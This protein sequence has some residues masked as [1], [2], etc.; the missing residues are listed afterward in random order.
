MK[1]YDVLV[2]GDLVSCDY[3]MAE[4]LSRFGMSTI[5]VRSRSGRNPISVPED[6]FRALPADH[7]IH[8][9]NALEF[10]S[11]ARKSRL[12][13]S[14]TGSLLFR[15]RWLWP[16][17]K[18]LGL[19]PVIHIM[20]GSDMTE[21][22]AERSL[23]GMLYRQYLRFVDL[24]WC[25]PLPHAL[26][27]CVD[28]KLRNVVF[29][30]GFPFLVP[31]I[32]KSDAY[33]GPKPGE[34]LRLFHC[35][36]FDWNLTDF[37]LQRN[38]I[39][40]NDKFLRAFIRAIKEGLDLRL[41]VLDRGADRLVAKEMLERGGVLDRVEWRGHLS[42][43]ELYEE[44]RRC[45]LVAN[46][47]AHGGAGGISFESMAL[48]RP[49]LQYANPT[50]F[51][52]MY[53]TT[54]TPFISCRTEDEILDALRRLST[55]AG[56]AEAA[57]KGQAWIGQYIDPDKALEKFRFYYTLLTGDERYFDY[58]PHFADSK[59]HAEAVAAGNY[60]PFAGLG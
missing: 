20:T 21:M 15:M 23:V 12:V 8:V 30:K 32:E 33:C 28:L 25:L 38:S 52:L 51:N 41:T 55:G 10:V 7:R 45:H 54:D 19:P 13:V 4:H 58:G 50:Y 59:R 3:I 26:K 14:L 56:L 46:M 24:I 31:Q 1:T 48:G 35:S 9:R 40:G 36:N 29:M 27:N 17:R 47:F 60:D 11:Y 57:E 6:Y 16:F 43:D 18:L 22:A 5:A 34:P 37:G 53:G 42:R 39:K 2:T 44:I 49:V